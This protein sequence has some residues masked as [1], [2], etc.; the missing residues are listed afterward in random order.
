MAIEFAGSPL[1]SYCSPENVVVIDRR[2]V[3]MLCIMQCIN[4]PCNVSL[5][6]VTALRDVCMYVCVLFVHS[7]ELLRN[8][9]GRIYILL[10][11]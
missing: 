7:D 9:S 3:P 11:V 10:D 5:I 2:S 6:E 1:Y 8:V 4:E